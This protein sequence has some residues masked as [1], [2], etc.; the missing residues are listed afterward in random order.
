M[1]AN[2]AVLPLGTPKIYAGLLAII[3]LCYCAW[4]LS[5]PLFPTQDGPMHLYFTH[6]L[7]SLLLHRGDLY[8]HYY[9]IRHILPPYALY[10]YALMALSS[11]LPI[12]LADKV[13]IC[14]YFISFAFGFRY[15][16]RA[17]GPNGDAMALLAT[18][19]M[20]N[21][22]L[23]M[24]FVNF[25]LSTSF[26][27]WALGLWC[28]AV[29]QAGRNIDHRRL[30]AFV[31]LCYLI[32]FTHPVPLLAVFGFCSLDLVVRLKR[33][34]RAQGVGIIPAAWAAQ[35]CYLIIG[36]GT[37]A[38]V[39]LFTTANVL[40]QVH[41]SPESRL[42][43]EL[44]LLKGYV[45]LHSL[46]A[47]A[48][49]SLTD[50]IYRLIF[51]G[52]LGGAIWLA[53]RQFRRARQVGGW[54][55]AETWTVASLLLLVA[56]PLIPSDL[57]NSA[58]FSARLIVFI[59]ISALIAASGASFN[60]DWVRPGLAAVTVAATV[61][62]LSMAERRIRPIAQD[63][64]SLEQLQPVSQHQ[65]G[66]LIHSP[67]YQLPSTTTYDPYF[68]SG[69]RLFRRNDSIL[70]NT[71]WLDLAIIPLGP[72]PGM[73]TYTVSANTLEYPPGLRKE[74]NS[75]TEVRGLMLSHVNFAL[76][77]FGRRHREEQYDPLLRSTTTQTKQ[78]ESLATTWDCDL[79][80]IYSLCERSGTTPP[81]T[82]G[83]PLPSADNVSR[84]GG[85]GD[86][87]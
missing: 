39:K 70:Y 34:R 4:V 47:F 84:T 71:P 16:A 59:W 24:G 25:C 55:M 48:G 66:L 83:R 57:N 12:L 17:V 8:S 80:T 37:L 69:V 15:L 62:T 20:L 54:S 49:R 3:V 65:V 52:L 61:L 13:I 32:M 29:L 46:T 40:H 81:K 44:S 51:Y 72:E 60:R 5:L 22:P 27:L 43:A 76:I 26:A 67:N 6:V 14:I 75:S 11:V 28:R 2:K 74:M 9:Y 50:S 23:G 63:L 42:H 58:Y 10:Y 68:W 19:I 87:S 41:V 73:P 35:L 45:L 82:A 56:F 38:Y 36:M 30:S 1:P 7:Q 18:V 79:Q 85:L 53:V 33:H 77:S 64:A 86:G 21:W 31:V 78:D